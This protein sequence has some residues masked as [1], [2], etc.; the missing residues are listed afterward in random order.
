VDSLYFTRFEKLLKR[1]APC[2][3]QICVAICLRVNRPEQTIL[4]PAIILFLVLIVKS[5]KTGFNVQFNEYFCC[6]RKLK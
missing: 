5:F 2:L 6:K 1:K 4:K 3:C